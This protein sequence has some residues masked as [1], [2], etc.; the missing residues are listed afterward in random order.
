MWTKPA[1]N[2]KTDREHR[3][4]LSTR[5][6][7]VLRQARKLS[8]G[9]LVFPGRKGRSLNNTTFIAALTRA[10]VDSAPHGFRSSFR[11]WLQERDDIEHHIAEL[12]ISH[13][14]G[15]TATEQ[16]YARSDMLEQRR[17]VMQADAIS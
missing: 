5:A 7:E 12:R 13:L 4:P 10:G 8:R 16:P 3:V 9:K 15:Y 17:P 11:T 2:T 6:V 1:E 14:G